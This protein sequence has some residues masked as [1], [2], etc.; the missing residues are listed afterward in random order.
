MNTRN[1]PSKV[2][3]RRFT[4]NNVEKYSLIK[5]LNLKNVSKIKMALNEYM[6]PN[7]SLFLEFGKFLLKYKAYNTLDFT[8][9]LIAFEKMKVQK[10]ILIVKRQSR[11]KKLIIPLGC[12]SSGSLGTQRS[13]LWTRHTKNLKHL[14]CTSP[15]YRYN[16]KIKSL[17]NDLFFWKAIKRN[18][19][20]VLNINQGILAGKSTT[21]VLKLNNTPNTVKELCL[22]NPTKLVDSIENDPKISLSSLKNLKSINLLLYADLKLWETLLTSIPNPN[23]LIKLHLYTFGKLK[24]DFNLSYFT[25]QENNQVRILELMFENIP[26]DIDNF[27]KSFQNGKLKTF[28]ISINEILLTPKENWFWIIDLLDNNPELEKIKIELSYPIN[29]SYTE[30]KFYKSLIKAISKLNQLKKFK[31]S[32]DDTDPNSAAGTVFSIK[33]LYKLKNIEEI[34]FESNCMAAQMWDDFIELS[35]H[36]SSN[37]KKLKLGLVK[38]TPD[39]SYSKQLLKLIPNLNVLEVLEL[40]WFEIPSSKYWKKFVNCLTELKNLRKLGLR[41]IHASEDELHQGTISIISMPSMQNIKYYGYF[42]NEVNIENQLVREQL[43]F[44]I[45]KMIK[46]RDI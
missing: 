29:E 44:N 18:R 19:L 13:I 6:R 10:Q 25:L 41:K 5:K 43:F 8:D 35:Q 4:L 39:V 21:F 14:D 26:K 3:F 1:S 28:K 38:I 34:S 30:D 32:L 27:T 7:S 11:I 45:K 42:R 22:K 40:K 31:L 17:D 24:K 15:Y 16:P 37:L 46:I 36:F 2:H 9:G 20:E 12:F 33:E 23:Q